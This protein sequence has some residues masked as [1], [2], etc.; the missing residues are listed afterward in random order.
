MSDRN[1][2]GQLARTLLR[3]PVPWVFVLTYLVG[4]GLETAFH[5]G[6]FIRGYRLLT[7]VGFAVFALGAGLAAWGWFIFRRARTTRVPGEASVALVT[8]GPYR[9]SR[10]PMYVGLSFAYLGEAA[11]LHQ[12]VPVVLLPLTMAYLNRIVVPLEEE[13]LRAVFGTEYERYQTGVRRWL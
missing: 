10:N 3:I 12:I 13:R 2:F 9:L 11:I 4:V 1:Q 5:P 6:G 8:W 7:P